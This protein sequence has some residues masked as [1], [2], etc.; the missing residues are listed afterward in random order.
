LRWSIDATRCATPFAAITIPNAYATGRI[1]RSP[2]PA[3]GDRLSRMA[4]AAMSPPSHHRNVKVGSGRSGKR[5]RIARTVGLYTD[6]KS[7][8]ASSA[9]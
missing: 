5:A 2:R 7:V 9:T 1:H 6:R 4:M 3:A 8:S